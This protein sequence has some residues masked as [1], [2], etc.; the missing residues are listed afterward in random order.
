MD[1]MRAGDMRRQALVTFK[2]PETL[3]EDID[4]LVKNGYFRSRSEALRYAIGL[5][6]EHYRPRGSRDGGEACR[7]SED[8][9]K[10]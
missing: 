2:I 4:V 5:L 1:P 6:I 7:A 9:D 8:A 10:G 3:L